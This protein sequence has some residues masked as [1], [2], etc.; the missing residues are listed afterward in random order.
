MIRWSCVVFRPRTTRLPSVSCDS[1]LARPHDGGCYG[2]AMGQRACSS[3]TVWTRATRRL[4]GPG[5]SISLRV[6]ADPTNIRS[7][8]TMDFL[9]DCWYAAAWVEEVECSRPL[10]RVIVDTPVLLLKGRDGVVHALENSCPHRF[11]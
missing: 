10:L 9:K 4:P 8:L 2:W 5:S 1:I 11:A 3:L 7:A 6:P